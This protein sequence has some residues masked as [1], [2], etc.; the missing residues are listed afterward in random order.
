MAMLTKGRAS[1]AAL[2]LLGLS[3]ALPSSA[4][5]APEVVL[6]GGTSFA[7]GFALPYMLTEFLKPRLEKYSNGRLSLEAH[8]AGSLCNEKSCVEQVKLG[9]ADLATVSIANYGGF[10]KT[11]E[12]LTLPYIFA[13]TP[14]AKKVMDQFLAKEL[15]TLGEK[16][17]NLK[18][19]AIVPMLGFRALQHNLGKLVK[20]PADIKNI[21]IRVTKSPLDGAL[22]R[23]WGAAATPVD[24]SETYDAIHQKVARGLYIPQGIYVKMKFNE[25]APQVTLTGGA[26]TPMMF[27]MDL[28]RYQKL[29]DWAR[30]AIDKAADELQAAA[31][32]IDAKFEAET[33]AI[34]QNAIKAGKVTVYQPTSDELKQWSKA[35]AQSWLIA[36][37]LGLY[38]TKLTRRILEAQPE[39]KEF[40]AELTKIGAL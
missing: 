33:D 40:L 26:W 9:Q 6:K 39:Q 38:D 12:L 24:W 30:A 18:V 25:V 34:V 1:A 35:A 7:K 23:A 5:A 17:E 22:L 13:D 28:K 37:K 19:L 29:P 16:N 2:A 11:F 4:V 36:K 21:K 8:I 20:T 3:L 32:D 27:F 15:H 14:S 31:F 10:G